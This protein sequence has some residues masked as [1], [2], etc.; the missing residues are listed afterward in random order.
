MAFTLLEGIVMVNIKVLG[1]SVFLLLTV[2]KKGHFLVVILA[3]ELI[4]TF[5]LC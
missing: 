2:S 3:L 5:F 4:A 1:Q